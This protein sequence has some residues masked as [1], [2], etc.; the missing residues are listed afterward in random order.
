MNDVLS[1]VGVVERSKPNFG[2]EGL[3]SNISNGQLNPTEEDATGEY[4]S[5]IAVLDYGLWTSWHSA[6]V[7]RLLVLSSRSSVI[8]SADQEGIPCFA[9]ELVLGIAEGPLHCFGIQNFHTSWFSQLSTK[10][11][12][13]PGE[14]ECNY[15]L[16]PGPSRFCDSP[17][18]SREGALRATASIYRRYSSSRI[19]YASFSIQ[20]A[21]EFTSSWFRPSHNVITTSQFMDTVSWYFRTPIRSRSFANHTFYAGSTSCVVGV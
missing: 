15:L 20:S 14:L 19:D 11:S 12:L 4:V 10:Y 18:H 2:F 1:V 7:M 5:N 9:K 16:L 13:H 17:L 3:D 21:F 6:F 8:T